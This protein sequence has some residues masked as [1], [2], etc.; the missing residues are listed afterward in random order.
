MPVLYD[1]KKLYDK[2]APKEDVHE[3]Y[4]QFEDKNFTNESGDSLLHLAAEYADFGAIELLLYEGAKANVVNKYDATPLHKIGDF[5]PRYYKYTDSDIYKTTALLVDAKV[6]TLRK[7]E[8]GLTCYHLAAQ[9]GIY[10]VIQAL[11]DKNVKMGLTDKD[12]C[13]ALHIACERVRHVISSLDYAKQKVG[14]IKDT[15]TPERASQLTADYEENKKK[16]EGYFLIVKAL[17]DAGYDSEAKDNYGR[18]PLDFA[19]Q[20]NANKIAALLKGDLTDD[21][22]ANELAIASGGMT[23]H[24]AAQKNDVVAIK[25]LA[26]M[27]AD[28][29][30]ESDIYPFEGVT[31]LGIACSF[32]LPESVEVL[33]EAGANPNYKSGK[34][35]R[36]PFYSLIMNSSVHV[37]G[38]IFT[39]KKVERIIQ[40]FIKAGWDINGFVDDHA[41]T[42]LT[43]C[44]KSCPGLSGYNSYRLKSHLALELIN[45]GCDVNIANLDGITPLMAIA[46]ENYEDVAEKVTLALL[47]NNAEVNVTDKY[48]NTPLMHIA[49]NRKQ[50][51]AKALIEVMI[52]VGDINTNT[53]NNAGKTALDIAT[54][55]GHE[56]LV[57]LLLSST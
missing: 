5:D 55:L 7:N 54:E 53:V 24:Q 47:E 39:E 22:K 50:N 14:N 51:L 12:G 1:I 29:N 2:N 52:E 38:K 34:G 4:R 35:G 49:Q 13:G 44:C 6:S 28:L 17:V 8:S 27:G 56:E 16:V 32:I 10:P 40:A 33:L 23:L 20:S 25:A 15:D 30:E 45:A 21:P 36:A 3:V 43:L 42:A 57:K 41:N 31:P 9:N 11:L 26:E 46:N 18:S 48:G 19:V 37:N